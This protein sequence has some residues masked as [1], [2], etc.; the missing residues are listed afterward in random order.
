[1]KESLF[2]IGVDLLWVRVNP[3]GKPAAGGTVSYISNILEGFR[4]YPVEDEEIYLYVCRD[5][6]HVFERFTED[7]RFHLIV[8]PVDSSSQL[9]R[10]VWENLN[11]NRLARRDQ[12]SVWYI[13]VYSRPLLM[14]RM[15]PD[16]TVIHDLISLHYPANFSKGRAKFFDLCWRNDAR[17]ASALVVISDYVRQDF[18]AHYRADEERV[19]VIYDPI[20]IR[21]S[22]VDFQELSE[23]YGIEEREYLY[24]VSAIMKHKNLI[25]LVKALN[26]L[27][28][29]GHGYRL[30]ISGVISDNSSDEI[31]SYVKEHALEEAV[32]YTGRVSDEE[33]DCLYEHCKTFLFPSLFEGFGM[34]VLEAME[35]GIPVITTKKTALYEVSQGQAEYV[36]DPLNEAEWAERIL[37]S[38]TG[39]V[40]YDADFSRYELNHIVGQYRDLFRYIYSRT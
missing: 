29:Q 6:A 38:P 16:V 11:M 28:D 9:R 40:H 22:P 35:R 4:Q 25:T 31:R 24:T 20:I 21:K 37:E 19:R 27:R 18:L 1:M 15:V 7:S 8:C 26:Y 17:K 34:P 33:R 2:R 5:A 39:R 14:N 13:P 32:I 36:E 3:D 23:R 12:L 10:I 30:V